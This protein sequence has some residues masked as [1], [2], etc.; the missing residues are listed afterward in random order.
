MQRALIALLIISVSITSC[1][2]TE[3][4][5]DDAGIDEQIETSLKDFEN[6]KR[7]TSFTAEILKKIPDDM[8]ETA[9][10]DYIADVKIKNHYD[11]EYYIIKSMSRGFQ[12]IYITW[13][14]ENEVN[15]G[16]F[17]QYFYNTS[18]KFNGEVVESLHNIGGYK[19]EKIVID[20]LAVYN[21]EIAIHNKAKQNGSMESFMNSYS[22]SELDRL[23]DLFYKSGE[24]L[25]KLRIRYIRENT[26][27][28][29]TK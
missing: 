16:G 8:L 21:K 28:F 3:N 9:V 12:N 4:K 18:G 20:A 27:Q 25:S 1:R 5:T 14:L 11:R 13:N 23:D 15:N 6:R 26:D 22:E 19:T 7:Y 24:D 10:L 29:I 2:K 17:I